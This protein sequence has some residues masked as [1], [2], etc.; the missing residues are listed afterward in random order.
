MA[1]TALAFSPDG[2][3]LAVSGYHEVTFWNPAT[4]AHGAG[5]QTG[6]AD[7]WAGVFA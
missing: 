7:Q 4:G 3:E 2:K 6:G 5:G 1:V